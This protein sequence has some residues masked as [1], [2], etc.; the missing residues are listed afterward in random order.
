MGC[1]GESVASGR[2]GTPYAHAVIIFETAAE[3]AIPHLR[4]RV[5]RSRYEDSCQCP[6]II[7]CTACKCKCG[8]AAMLLLGGTAVD[9]FYF[10]LPA[11]CPAASAPSH[12]AVPCRA[13]TTGRDA[14]LCTS[15]VVPV[16][17]MQ[18]S[19][20]L[21]EGPTDRRTGR[22]VWASRAARRGRRYVHL[23]EPIRSGPL[24]FYVVLFIF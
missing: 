21:A 8:A 12:E 7:P 13:D 4:L 9:G 14:C 5:S 22:V 2:F 17:A 6:P 19:G 16:R 23:A 24:N 10:L 18:R 20:G 1:F 15:A 3:A 11:H